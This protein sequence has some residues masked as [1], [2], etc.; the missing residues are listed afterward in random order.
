M[1]AFL[2]INRN[3]SRRMECPKSLLGGKSVQRVLLDGNF[4]VVIILE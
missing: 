1:E 3:V 2:V 4:L